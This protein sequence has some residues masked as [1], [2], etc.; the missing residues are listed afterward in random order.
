[1][2]GQA[3]VALERT[4]IAD[5]ARRVHL[6]AETEHLRTALLSSL[7][8]D[9]RTPLGVIEGAASALLERD[10]QS[11]DVRRELAASVLEESL[12]MNR[13][14]ADLLA[15]VRLESGE[16]TVKREWH[17]LAE[18]VGVALERTEAVLAG[19][20]VHVELP[21][22]LPLVPVDEVLVEQVLVNL[23]ENAAKHTPAGTAVEI[24]AD[25]V[26]GAVEVQVADHGPGLPAGMEGR[27]F[28]KFERAGASAAGAG[29]GLTIARGMIMAHGGRIRAGNRPGGGAVFTFTLP[30][31]GTPP[32]M[33]RDPEAAARRCSI[34]SW[35]AGV[36]P[37][38]RLARVWK[39]CA[40]SASPTSSAVASS[41]STWQVGLP[42]R[43][44][45]SSMQ[46]RSSCTRE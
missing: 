31:I 1:M 30:I 18:L 35:R 22:D 37:A 21:D 34:S 4:D 26:P 43:R 12:R 46:G 38:R 36:M 16:L 20:P 33:P 11:A 14:V 27:I 44:T 7:S 15:M 39:A 23:L 8:H 17:V 29:L 6:L 40:C 42:R 45:S 9:L 41:N 25:T 10:D 2:I 19:R 24:R 5:Q 28:E 32:A 13:L 3:A